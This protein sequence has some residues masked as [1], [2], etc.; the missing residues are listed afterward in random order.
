L[1]DVAIE[2][3]SSKLT[4]VGIGASA[5]GLAAL[6][7][8]FDRVPA[9]SD[10]A[11]VVI[12][13]LSP[14]HKSHL[15]DLLQPHVQFP[16]QQVTQTTPLEPNRAYII[17]PNANI[18]AIDTHLRLS[19]FGEPRGHR[20]PIDHFFRTLAATHD[21]HSVGII[22]TGTGSDGTLGI[23][24]IKAKGG[25][26]IVQDPNDAEY[27]GM[28]QSAIA[29]GVA[30]LILPVGEISE[31]ILRFSK[32]KPRVSIPDDD[33]AVEHTDYAFLQKI[34]THI[35]ARTD[36]DF[37]QYKRST[38]MRRITRRM[39]L[40]YLEDLPSY[41][42]RLRERPN[43]VLALA[44]DL[45]VTVTNFFRDPEVYKKL[46]SDTIPRLFEKKGPGEPIRIWSVGC[47]TGEEAYS[48]AIVL[49]EEA[50]RRQTS[51]LV[52]IFATDLHK[53]SLE[54]AREGFYPGDIE[55]DVNP[56]RLRRFFVR[57][58]GGYRILKEVRELVVYAPH[59]LLADP[60][61][62]RLD[63]IGCRNV[64]IY[65]EREVQRAVIELFH[66]ALNPEGTLLVGAAETI[67]TSDLF[68]TEDK[69]LCLYRKRN[70]PAPSLAYRFSRLAARGCS[71]SLRER[72]PIRVN[73]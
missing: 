25:L 27:D 61:F 22:L 59:N 30:D 60:P 34:L 2:N 46:A 5:G 55:T 57:E 58:S 31:A 13:H 50:A 12:V 62:S 42:D 26:I 49:L 20:T 47:A 4:V 21:G 32:T 56:D 64:L 63:L 41:L 48:L 33:Q 19:E 69:A 65:L 54:K 11:F 53:H 8:F 28:P 10:I 39:Q 1:S 68:R 45:L 29:T 9:Q 52:Q 44:D 14:E 24:D 71:A 17:P 38:I 6:K 72:L 70:V 3:G 73:P 23:K 16:V 35:R 15:A 37:S 43:E 36:R 66:Y 18:D 7:R 51:P 40:N 67:D